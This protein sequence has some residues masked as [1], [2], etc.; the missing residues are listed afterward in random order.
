MYATDG[1]AMGLRPSGNP[2][3]G[4]AVSD[5][6]PNSETPYWEHPQIYTLMLII[7]T[8]EISEPGELRICSQADW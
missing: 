8:D 7:F 2:V 1:A 3:V 4:T 6:N 5:C